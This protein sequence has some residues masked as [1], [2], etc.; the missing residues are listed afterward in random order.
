MPNRKDLTT[1]FTMPFN[2]IFQPRQLQRITF[3]QGPGVEAGIVNVAMQ[4]AGCLLTW[5][6]IQR[7]FP[8][9]PDSAI[10][11]NGMLFRLRKAN[12]KQLNRLSLIYR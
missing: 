2:P 5:L 6:W 9:Q 7:P 1:L 4:R 10:N 3:E 11:F 12:G 8:A